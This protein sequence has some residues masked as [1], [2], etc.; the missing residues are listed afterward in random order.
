MLLEGSSKGIFDGVFSD[1]Q[2]AFPSPKNPLVYP[3]I[4]LFTRRRDTYRKL[5]RSL[6][7]S[8]GLLCGS[9]ESLLEKGSLRGIPPERRRYFRRTGQKS[10]QRSHKAWNSPWVAISLR[11]EVVA[12]TWFTLSQRDTKFRPEENPWERI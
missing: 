2:V 10:R 4:L 5:S 11:G 1:H 8:S 6:K 9:S 3:E 12:I 7:R